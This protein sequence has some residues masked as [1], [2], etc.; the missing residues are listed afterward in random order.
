LNR[1]ERRQFEGGG[2]VVKNN[3]NAPG[4]NTCS[5]YHPFSYVRDQL[6]AGLEIVDFQAEGA[7]GNPHQDLYVLRKT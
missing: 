1:A 2:L 5:A 7:R 3:V 6:A 4:S